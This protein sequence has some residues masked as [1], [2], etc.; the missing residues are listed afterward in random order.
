MSGYVEEF[1][2]VAICF[3]IVVICGA[4]AR[5]LYVSVIVPMLFAH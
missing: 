4:V 1:I 3:I 5:R 2:I